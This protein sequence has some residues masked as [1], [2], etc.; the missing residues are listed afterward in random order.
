VDT[1]R[2]TRVGVP[3]LAALL[4]EFAVPAAFLFSLGPD[5]TGKAIRRV[6]R[7]GF[8]RKVSRTGVVRMYGMR[9]LLNGTLLPAP[10]IGK[11]HAEVMRQVRDAGFETGI[12]CHD[13]FKWQDYLV[14]MSLTQV[15][16]EFVRARDEFRR[17]F[18]CEAATAGAPGWQASAH[19]RQVYDEAA[20]LYS[21]DTRGDSAYF[22]EIGG[23]AF[24]TLEI[25]STLP[26]FD[27]LLGRPEY[28]EENIVAHYGGLLRHG[29]PNILTIHA[30]IEGMAKLALFRKLLAAWTDLGVT[31][32]RLDELAR[33]LLDQRQNVP[34]MPLVMAEIDGRSG[35]VATQGSVAAGSCRAGAST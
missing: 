1:E 12:H 5:N 10:H 32:I 4:T 18:G 19:S 28:P 16:D 20:L 13:H 26:T 21:S 15:R 22:P 3:A 23:R 33:K 34:Q 24:K 9:T 2:G 6:F 30:E 7:P 31:F 17:I 29:R 14:R 11:R 35:K 25:P 27:E 8:F